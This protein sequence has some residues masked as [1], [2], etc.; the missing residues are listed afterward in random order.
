MEVG[1]KVGR[2]GGLRFN[3][4]PKFNLGFIVLDFEFQKFCLSNLI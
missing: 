4:F 3:L 2:E 1:E